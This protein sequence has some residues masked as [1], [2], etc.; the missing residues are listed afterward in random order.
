MQ[1]K[2]SER[3]KNKDAS[4]DKKKVN[5]V[6]KKVFIDDLGTKVETVVITHL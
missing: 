1:E 5:H 3:Q 4:F 2:L 6:D